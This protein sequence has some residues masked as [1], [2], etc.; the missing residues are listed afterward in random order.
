M[1]HDQLQINHLSFHLVRAGPETGPLLILL[2]GFPEFWYGWRSQIPFLAG[3]GFRVWAPDMRGVN[4]SEKPEDISAYRIDH[5]A[6]DVIGLLDAAGEQEAFLVGHDWGAAVAWWT[7]AAYPDR[8]ARLVAINVPHG[9]V[10]RRHLRRSPRQLL[11]SWYIFFF[12]LPW[13]PELLSRCCRWRL[14][15]RALQATSRPGTF[16]EEELDR[17]REAWSRPGAYTAMLNYY[18]AALQHS[19]KPLADSRIKV[20]TLLIWGARDRFLGRELAQ[21]SIELCDQGQLV[22][23]EDASHW[24]QHEEAGQVNRLI[25]GFFKQ[26]SS[27]LVSNQFPHRTAYD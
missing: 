26:Q 1:I 11:R 24:V 14:P 18:R 6:A 27:D 19:A 25:Q 15:S 5:L 20:P 7:A 4:R 2:H 9:E 16:T 8:I 12:Q 17:Y 13:L 10:M 22:V 23:L 21:P 3:A